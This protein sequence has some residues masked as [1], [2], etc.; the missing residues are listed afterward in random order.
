MKQLLS[1][2]LSA[3]MLLSLVPLSMFVISAEETIGGTNVAL[4]K[5]YTGGDVVAATSTYSANLTD[6][7]A[8]EYGAYD[9]SWFSFWYYEDATS[10][11][12]PDG[13]GTIVID[14]L[15]VVDKITDVRVNVWN[16]NA[17]GIATAKS[18]T[19]YISKD[20]V[21][22]T[23]LGKLDIPDGDDPD[24]ATL[25]VN[26]ASARYVRIVVETRGTFTFLNEIEVIVGGNYIPK[27]DASDEDT[28]EPD[29]DSQG[30]KYSLSADGT[31]YIVTDFDE[32]VTEVVIPTEFN[33]LP[34]KEIGD[35][36]FK[37]C[38]DLTSIEIPN[39]VTSIGDWAFDYC[40]SLTSI[41]IPDSVKSIGD[42]AFEY[43]ESLT[44]VEI[45][46]S[47]TSIGYWAFSYC[48]SLTDIYCEAESKPDGW[49]DYWNYNCAATVHWGSKMPD[50]TK[51]TLGNIDGDEDV[52]ASDYILIK[53]AV[54]KTYNLTEEQRIVADID[55]DGDVDATDYVLV[56][57]IVLGTYK[58]D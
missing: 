41:E 56:K 11:N 46:N 29:I 33:G 1:V 30:A 45:G 12:A 40:F 5:P 44:S 25:N 10:T 7:K 23:K 28:W 31:Y 54:L 16:C 49:G 55:K 14:L 32:S 8:S 52:D 27:E 48:E 19:A 50:E 3:I 24:W 4:D 26:N 37:Y 42:Y 18:I 35:S 38:Y 47:V 2:I 17:S 36:A 15:E 20:D 22:Y 34:V 39:S 9:S 21:S 13:I 43:C 51:P 57:R 6:G 58:V 53:R